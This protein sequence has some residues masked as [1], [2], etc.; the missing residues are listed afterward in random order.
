MLLIKKANVVRILIDPDYK[1][2]L[3]LNMNA[4]F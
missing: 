1:N 2:I 3:I 4:N